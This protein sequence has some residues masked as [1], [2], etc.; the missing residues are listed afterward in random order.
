LQGYP[1]FKGNILFIICKPVFQNFKIVDLTPIIFIVF[2]HFLPAALSQIIMVI[3]LYALGFHHGFPLYT[4]IRIKRVF[5]FNTLMIFLS[6]VGGGGYNLPSI[7]LYHQYFSI[8]R[9][10]ADIA[11]R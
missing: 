1:F 2:L 5:G 11:K 9:K 7:G 3:I 6:Q 8:I 4:S 10:I